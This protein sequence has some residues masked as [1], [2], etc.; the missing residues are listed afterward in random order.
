[1]RGV[2]GWGAWGAPGLDVASWSRGQPG[3]DKSQESP[4]L[5]GRSGAISRS[6]PEL[7]TRSRVAPRGGDVLG[8]P[9]AA[10]AGRARRLCDALQSAGTVRAPGARCSRSGAPAER[11]L[12]ANASKQRALGANPQLAPAVQRA[13]HRPKDNPRSCLVSCG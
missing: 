12:F 7:R 5:K 3:E 2:K 4:T 13:G 8:R 1:V 11:T 6:R 9:G 10:G